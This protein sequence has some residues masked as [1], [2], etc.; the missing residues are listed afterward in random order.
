MLT[1]FTSLID[2]R[3][4]NPQ[5]APVFTRIEHRISNSTKNQ[6]DHVCLCNVVLTSAPCDIGL[7]SWTAPCHSFFL[8]FR[9]AIFTLDIGGIEGGRGSMIMVVASAVANDKM[10]YLVYLRGCL[11]CLWLDENQAKQLVSSST[12]TKFSLGDEVFGRGL[13]A[14]NKKVAALMHSCASLSPLPRI[15]RGLIFDP[16]T[17]VFGVIQTNTS[18]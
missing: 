14:R 8:F 17:D 13:R 10:R 2:P 12:L 11:T 9:F 18:E 4:V 15:N 5:L 7:S 16:W 1:R 3:H 6:P